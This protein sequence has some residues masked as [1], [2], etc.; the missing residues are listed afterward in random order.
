MVHDPRR[1]P[2]AQRAEQL[3]RR[4]SLGV[5]PPSLTEEDAL[6]I[7]PQFGPNERMFESYEQDT[8]SLD[9]LD[10][11]EEHPL[12][13]AFKKGDVR[14]AN[15][16]H[17]GEMVIVDRRLDV[18][19]N[20]DDK[21]PRQKYGKGDFAEMDRMASL[22]QLQYV[23]GKQMVIYAVTDFTA[24]NGTNSDGTTAYL[25]PLNQPPVQPAPVAFVASPPIGGAILTGE[26]DIGFDGASDHVI[27]D[28]PPG[29]IVKIPFA[30]N[31]GKLA[32]RL[33]PKYYTPIDD[34]ANHLRQ[35]LV[36]PGGPVLTNEMWN[37]LPTQI[38]AQ[39]AFPNFQPQPCRGWISEGFLSND[40]QR[41]PTRRFYG[42]VKAT[43]T[44]A[45]WSTRCPIA[46]AAT[47]VML[48]GGFFDA[49]NPALQSLAFVQNGLGTTGA[50]IQQAG[51]FPMNQIVPLINNCQSIDIFNSPNPIGGG[52]F[53]AVAEMPFELIYFLSP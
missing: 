39:N 10:W 8:G 37:S 53:G 26:I 12:W 38:M 35:Y 20:M 43:G 46:F 45:Q 50:P 17:T 44:L 41:A 19:T 23:L 33:R 34:A 51:Q 3:A 47:H 27:F 36:S 13:L 14:L 7:P 42:S 29:Q 11:N 24:P 1:D 2:R 16:P 25:S 21:L 30:G 49:V 9:P 5:A 31:F 6:S 52:L 48:V 4:T 15:D 22:A 18:Q 40:L 32:A 28:M